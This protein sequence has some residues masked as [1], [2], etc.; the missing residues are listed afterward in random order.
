VPHVLGLI[1]R[2]IVATIVMI[3]VVSL[4]SFSGTL[5]MPNDAAKVQAGPLATQE[6]I[7]QLRDDLGLNDPALV[8]YVRGLKN[9]ARL[10][11]GKSYTTTLPVSGLIR[12]RIGITMTLA[13]TSL[14][15]SV[16]A[17]V[18]MGLSGA[19]HPGSR[20]DR[21]YL[22]VAAICTATP[23]FWFALVLIKLFAI[24]V[25]WL[26][27]V[28]WTAFSVSP[29]GWLKSLLLPTIAMSLFSTAALFRMS[30]VSLGG[31]LNQDFIR[32]ARVKGLGRRR[33]LWRHALRPAMGPVVALA[34][35]Q[36]IV[37]FGQAA[38][39]EIIFSL[40][41]LG[42]TIVDAAAKV[43]APVIQGITMTVALIIGFTNLFADLLQAWINPK[44]R[45][46]S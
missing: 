4:L 37:G 15:V 36:F 29:L 22:L 43:D 6:Q 11:F 21:I 27:A 16:V 39:V 1:R 24:N 42:R 33:I 34:G 32:A 2:R 26:P 20:R 45:S 12:K 35:L 19:L 7:N 41:G 5:L 13:L 38:L 31:T 10:D 8:R 17:G 28:G 30:R 23:A 14:L 46:G 9:M 40:P 44:L 3:F 25:R 18:G